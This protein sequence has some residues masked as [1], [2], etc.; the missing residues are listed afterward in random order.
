MKK[1]NEN[2]IKKQI[3]T[4]LELNGWDVYRINNAGM[5]NAKRQEFIFH[6]KKGFSDLVAIKDNVLLF[7]ETKAPGKKASKEQEQ[8]L[9][10]VG[11]C[12]IVNGIVADSL[13]VVEDFLHSNYL[14]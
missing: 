7:I 4:Y 13:K 11:R 5:F 6:G 2:D 3:K 8:F 10:S 1:I 9:E 12:C 14:S